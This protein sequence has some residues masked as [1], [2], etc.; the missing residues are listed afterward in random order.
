MDTATVE[1]DP[2]EATRRFEWARRSGHPLYVWPEVA[3]G[4]WIGSCRAV[5]RALATGLSDPGGLVEVEAPAGPVALGVAAYTTGCGAILGRWLERGHARACPDTAAVLKDHLRHGRRRARK[6]T[7]LLQHVA[8]SF[9]EAGVGAVLF[10]G[11]QTAMS[12]FDEPALRPMA[13]LDLLVAPGDLP[14]A[15]KALAAAGFMRIVRQT[16]PVRSSWRPPGED[17]TLRSVHIPHARNPV[18]VD[19]HAGLARDFYGVGCVDPGRPGPE[20]LVDVR[21]APEGLC[22]LDDSTLFVVLAAHASEDLHNLQLVRLVELALLGRRIGARDGWGSVVERAG[23]AGSPHLLYPAVALADRLMAGAV[24]PDLV[25]WARSPAPAV[26][27]R[28]VDQLTPG[29]AQRLDRLGLLERFMWARTPGAVLRRL[30][31]MVAPASVG[32]SPGA[33]A[34]LYRNR[35]YRV[36]RGR[37]GLSGDP[38][39]LDG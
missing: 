34:A 14:A 18:S 13:D 3:I 36:I 11:G 22:G 15:E 31:H 27:R 24:A 5:E 32:G 19:L 29:T 9:R 35:V 7:D 4:D 33:L 20:D 30:G 23:A 28:V 6:L 38:G 1:L 12:L 21:G 39:G 25:A 8:S 26:M 17:G 37:V 2:E 10:K 16:R